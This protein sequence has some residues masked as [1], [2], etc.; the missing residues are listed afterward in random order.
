MWRD[1]S[2]GG[3]ALSGLGYYLI[4][5]ITH[6][7]NPER[8][9]TKVHSD[10]EV[11]YFD[12]LFYSIACFVAQ[13]YR[14]LKWRIKNCRGVKTWTLA[15][16]YCSAIMRWIFRQLGQ[17]VF[18]SRRHAECGCR[19]H[20]SR[21]EDFKKNQPLLITI[22]STTNIFSYTLGDF[23]VGVSAGVCCTKCTLNTGFNTNF[24]IAHC[25]SNNVT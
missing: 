16:N 21:R 25:L 3:D 24:E 23:K 15:A 13:I 1:P 4:I 19:M 17:W 6:L 18:M 8:D 20:F 5:S 7:R 12:N 10:F 14:L 11:N 2:G 22:W 9:S